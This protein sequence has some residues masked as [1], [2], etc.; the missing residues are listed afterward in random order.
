MKNSTAIRQPVTNIIYQSFMNQK[1]IQ[2]TI[3]L[4]Q[5]EL[6]DKDDYIGFLLSDPD[7]INFLSTDSQTITEYDIDSEAEVR[8]VIQLS[9]NKY[10]YERSVYTFFMLIGDVGGFNAAIIIL[11]TYVMAF[12]NKRMYEGSIS[13]EIP[14]RKSK[15]KV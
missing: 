5:N 8:I 14:A 4:A 15:K 11:P 6:V 12:Y 1:S 7:P 2:H 13:E 3:D 9:A 10:I